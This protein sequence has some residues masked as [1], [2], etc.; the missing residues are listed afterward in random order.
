MPISLSA[1]LCIFFRSDVSRLKLSV[2]YQHVRHD[3]PHVSL[4]H[5]FAYGHIFVGG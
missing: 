5:D 4:S 2:G 3:A 1:V